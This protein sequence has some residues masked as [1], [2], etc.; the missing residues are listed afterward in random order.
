M[1]E[2][3]RIFEEYAREIDVEKYHSSHLQTV[4]EQID[5]LNTIQ[6]LL[7]HIFGKPRVPLQN[8]LVEPQ[9]VWNNEDKSLMEDFESSA[10]DLIS[11]LEF[12]LDLKKI[13]EGLHHL[14]V[15]FNNCA[16]QTLELIRRYNLA[17]PE[18]NQKIQ[19]SLKSKQ[20]LEWFSAA[21]ANIFRSGTKFDN[22]YS[23][24][25]YSEI[26]LKHHFQLSHFNHIFQG[27]LIKC[28][29]NYHIG[30]FLN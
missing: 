5:Q 27:Q 17:P 19:N 8:S 10:W 30:E 22:D 1:L 24:A 28:F 7:E 4:K 18:L 20:G 13:P 3:S 25:P 26:H 16:L 23:W 6:N 29:S 14:Q 2:S 21:S 9:R 12:I 15:V 11:S